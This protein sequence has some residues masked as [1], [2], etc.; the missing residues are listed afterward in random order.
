MADMRDRLRK[1]WP[2]LKTLLAV[3]ILA[4]VAWFFVRILQSPELQETDPSRSP[5]QIVWDRIT[6]ARP[7]DL[8]AGAVLYLI[9]LSCYGLFWL[10]LLH[11]AGEP[12]PLWTALRIYYISHLGKY[13]PLGKGWA[14]LLRVSLSAA[15]GVRAGLAALT[16]AYETLT[17]MAAGALLAAVVIAWQPGDA[18]SHLWRAL[19]LLALAG[20]PILPGVFNR[21]VRGVAGRFG[22]ADNAVLPSMSAGMLLSGLGLSACGWTLLGGSLAAVL[23]ALSPERQAWTAAL[24][25]EC[26]AFVAVS[27]VAGFVASTPGG[28]GVRELVL[29]QF[30]QPKLGAQAVIVVV[31]LRLVWTVAELT[32]AGVLYWVPTSPMGNAPL[33]S[34]VL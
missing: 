4:G 1:Y 5:G 29:Q 25:L 9:G 27:Y 11:L 23:N 20:I 6:S 16:G 31:L 8:L 21:L 24:W 7:G 34:E 26:T 19:G 13:A 22:N 18:G 15:A 30:L 28:L 33:A 17:M 14:L 32:A 2:L 10:R 3:A 12:L